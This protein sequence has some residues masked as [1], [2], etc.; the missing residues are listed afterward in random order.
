MSPPLHIG[1][2]DTDSVRRGCTTYVA[3][4]LV[5]RLSLLGATFVDYPNL[6]RLNPNVPWKTRGNGALCLRIEADGG[7]T[8]KIFDVVVETVEEHSDLDWEGTDPGVVFYR[9]EGVPPE[10]RDFAERAIRDIVG[11]GEAVELIRRFGAEAVGFKG[12]R[13]II[14]ALAAIG[15]TLVGDHTFEL[16]AYRTPGMRGRPRRVLP[17]SVFRM[18]E[19]TRGLTF[20]NVDPEKGRVMITPRGPDP[21]LYG[22]RGESPEAVRRAGE[23]VEVEEEVERWVIFR[24]NQ[25][26]DGH[27]SRVGGIAR[28]RP[29]R[30]VVV[31]GSVAGRPRTIPLRHVIFTLGDGTG[32]VDC[33]A[34]E[35]TGKFRNV[36]KR[37]ELGDVVEVYGGVRPASQS[38]PQTINLEK[39]RVLE[40]VPKTTLR[41][42]RCPLCGR[43]MKSMGR[44]KGFR[45]P[46]CGHEDSEGEKTLIQLR[47]DL[48]EGL[49]IPPPRAQ[50]HLTK[51]L[52]RYGLEKEASPGHGHPK[53]E[54]FWG[55]G[56]S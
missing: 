47:R 25:G 39:I 8:D 9:G 31:G 11:L 55:L 2:D 17:E 50:R 22:I 6:T 46:R 13:G 40:L 49:Y 7:S 53:P 56:H 37:L 5:E 51:P 42:P 20:N 54:N 41:N 24:T 1:I 43:R 19:E 27:L 48:S 3:A 4:L 15:E 52:T 44:L 16:I 36:V 14:G 34:Y 23:I 26:T 28:I 18:E 29:F 21:V 30:P 38:H 10:I 45:C 35:P 12:G 33:A 32:S